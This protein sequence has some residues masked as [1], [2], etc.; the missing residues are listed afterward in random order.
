ML[1]PDLFRNSAFPRNAGARP[2]RADGTAAEVVRPL[3][4]L[5][6]WLALVGPHLTLSD[7]AHRGPSDEIRFAVLA[8]DGRHGPAPLR[9]LPG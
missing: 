5:D 9:K 1:Q 7:F 6:G 8:R 3:R 2:P 4:E